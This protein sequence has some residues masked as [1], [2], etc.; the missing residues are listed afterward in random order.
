M[1][2]ERYVD[3]LM[4]IFSFTA[5]KDV[6]LLK[7]VST[8][9]MFVYNRKANIKKFNL[10]D[11]EISEDVNRKITVWLEKNVDVEDVLHGLKSKG[12]AL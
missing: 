2:E 3:K 8:Q 10:I 1:A 4:S 7:N 11:E 12:M 5:G 9:V 6:G